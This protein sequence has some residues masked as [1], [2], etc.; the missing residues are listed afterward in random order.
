MTVSELIEE[1]RKYPP[2]MSL[3]RY[4]TPDCYVAFNPNI[5]LKTLYICGDQLYCP[6]EYPP[7]EADI[8]ENMLC[9]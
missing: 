2:D 7:E 9:I 3:V 4:V 6:K 8:V 5:R 1:L